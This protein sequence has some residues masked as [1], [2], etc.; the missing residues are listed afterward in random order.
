V[1]KAKGET[2]HVSAKVSPD[3]AKAAKIQAIKDGVSLQAWISQA[4]TLRLAA[5]Q[6]SAGT[7][8]D[9]PQGAA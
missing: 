7:D 9:P 1:K 4:I 3:V 2:I 6:A 5:V 8:R